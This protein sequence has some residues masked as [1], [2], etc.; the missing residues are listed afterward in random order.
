MKE[1]KQL[2]M[3]MLM[4]VLSAGLASCGGS[5]D[6][7]PTVTPTTPSTETPATPEVKV[8]HEYVDLGLPSKTLWATCN[9]GAEK[10]EDY[11]LYFAWGET[12]GYTATD[13]HSFEWK[14]LAYCSGNTEKGPFTRYVGTNDYGKE[15]GN[16]E[17]LPEDDAATKNWG[18]DWR[19]PTAE[20]FVEL[21]NSY[22]T[23][24]EWTKK[25]GVYGRLI[26][27]KTNDNTLFLPAAG[28]RV[29]NDIRMRGEYGCCWSCSLL[30][31]NSSEAFY[32]NFSSVNIDSYKDSRYYGRSIR[33][34]RV[35]K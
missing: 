24:T 25:N 27:S 11:G 31:T 23:K 1:L 6:D 14:N 5:D 19:M 21:L 12:K 9:I 35:K 17:L 20:Q 26:T 28:I 13:A 15:D 2:F 10:P 30:P 32:L 4:A 33:P 18:E 16:M 8:S 34:V 7:D 22:Y 29:N 3:L